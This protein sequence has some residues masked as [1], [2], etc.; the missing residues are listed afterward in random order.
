MWAVSIFVWRSTGINYIQLL[1]LQNTDISALFARQPKQVEINVLHLTMDLSL[2]YLL[3]FLLFNK[4]LR[5]IV[6]LPGDAAVAHAIPVLLLVYFLYRFFFPFHKRRVY[7]LM[8]AKVLMAPFQPVQFRDGYIG[9]S[10]IPQ[11]LSLSHH[12]CLSCSLSLSA[13]DL[14]TSLVR[15]FGNLSFSLIYLLLTL[16]WWLTNHVSAAESIHSPTW[17]HSPLYR[18]VLIPFLTLSPLWIRLMQCLRRS[19]ETGKRWP[20]YFNALKYTS[21]II[22]FSW[23]LFRPGAQQSPLWIVSLIAAT[24]YQFVWDVTM[25]WGLVQWSDRR[26]R[27]VF[28]KERSLCSTRW[29]LVTIAINL[30]L[31]FSWAVTLLPEDLTRYLPLLLVLPCLCI[32]YSL[33]PPPLRYSSLY[34]YLYSNFHTVMAATEIVRRMVWGFFRLEWEFIERYGSA[35]VPVSQMEALEVERSVMYQRAGAGGTV[36]HPHRHSSHLT[37]LSSPASRP[38]P[39]PLPPRPRHSK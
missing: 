28:R 2:V 29:Y 17:Q 9:Q 13:G 33:R 4:T 15:V 23:S 10:T 25:D 34:S 35:P 38:T 14:L 1:S 20:H 5:G 12:F 24:C 32:P 37:L 16:Y 30:L 6:T 7:L 31:R 11:S 22:V 19:V 21:A 3:S 8:L 39:P 36:C 27:F 26:K 18:H